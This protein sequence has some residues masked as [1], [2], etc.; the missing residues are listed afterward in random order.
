MQKI[1]RLVHKRNH[2]LT[3]AIKPLFFSFCHNEWSSGYSM[4]MSR[5]IYIYDMLV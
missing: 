1:G 4:I 2:I 5:I 3:Y